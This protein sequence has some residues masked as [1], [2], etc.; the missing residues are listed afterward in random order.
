[1][2][3]LPGLS[4]RFS[5]TAGDGED[6]YMVY[7]MRRTTWNL[8]ATVAALVALAACAQPL[9]RLQTGPD[10]VVSPEGLHKIDNSAFELAFARPGV[11]F[12]QYDKFILEPLQIASNA[13]QVNTETGSRSR[14]ERWEFDARGVERLKGELRDAIVEALE[15][16]RGYPVVTEPAPGVLRIVAAIV[17]IDMPPPPKRKGVRGEGGS[18]SSVTHTAGMMTLAMDLRDSLSHELLATV[19]DR[20]HAGDAVRGTTSFNNWRFIRI[21]CESWAKT[22]RSRVD[23]VHEHGLN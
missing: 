6:S 20:G 4:A 18:S 5:D 10:A 19:L 3:D 7:P 15:A 11:D 9:P 1:M 13:A 16:D 23:L 21:I 12:S 2:A 22:L 14:R 17:T 8:V